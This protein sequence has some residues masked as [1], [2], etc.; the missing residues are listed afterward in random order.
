MPRW[1]FILNAKRCVTVDSSPQSLHISI[2]IFTII[3]R[4]YFN[5][6]LKI[7]ATAVK[8]DAHVS[9][10]AKLKLSTRV[11]DIGRRIQYVQHSTF[12]FTTNPAIHRNI[13]S[14]IEYVEACSRHS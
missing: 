5:Q 7:S 1:W 9:A 10:A 8:N 3:G 13:I 14:G 6:L 2:I 12:I 4:E 11:S